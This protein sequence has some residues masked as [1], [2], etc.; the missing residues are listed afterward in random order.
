LSP[1]TSPSA[2]AAF[3]EGFV[4]GGGTLLLHDADLRTAIDR[5][6]SSLSASAF[7]GIVPL[8]RRTFGSFETAERRRLGRLAVAG[9]VAIPTGL[10]ADQHLDQ[11]VDQDR[12]VVV[13]RTV[14]DLIGLPAS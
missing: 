10:D 5:W 8:L 12:A 2:A 4:A 14:R 9:D 1:G 3:V 13:L 11:H 7:D 6:M